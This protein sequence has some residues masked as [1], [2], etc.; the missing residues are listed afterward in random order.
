[1]SG[2]APPGPGSTVEQD[3]RGILAPWLFR[4]RTRFAR[5]APDAALAGVVDWFWCVRWDLPD[6]TVHR[7]QVLQHPAVNIS[8]ATPDGRTGRRDIEARLT[9]TAMGVVDRELRGRGWVVGVKTAVG[10]AGAL[11]EGAVSDL[12]DRVVDVDLAG[13]DGPALVRD[14]VAAAPDAGCAC[15]PPGPDGDPGAH[16]AEREPLRVAVLAR[17]LTGAL[18]RADPDRVA[19]AHQVAAVARLAET[20]RGLRRLDDLAER[21]GH[22]PRALQRMFARHAGV[23]PTWVLRRYRILDAAEAVR[24]GERVAWAELAVDLGYADQAHLV[25][26]FKGAVGQTPAAYARS[27]PTPAP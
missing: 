20:D 12:V 13:L 2:S 6:G 22:G 7:Q 8:V 25:R 1:M 17:A 18:A 11:V 21:T 3:S 4:R 19:A 23:S 16:D 27:R 5:Y 9:G 15:G 24:S 14:V 26:D 10:G